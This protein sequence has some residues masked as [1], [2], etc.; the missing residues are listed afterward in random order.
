MHS[1]LSVLHKIW[2]NI[3]YVGSDFV[4]RHVG[5]CTAKQPHQGEPTVEAE[6][7]GGQTVRGLEEFIVCFPA[8]PRNPEST[9]GP[10]TARPC[11]P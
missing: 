11:I 8:S 3:A 9:L 5:Y 6:T 1:Y 4:R 2:R 10:K 7:V